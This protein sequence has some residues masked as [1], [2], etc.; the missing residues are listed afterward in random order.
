MFDRVYSFIQENIANI[1]IPTIKVTDVV[2]IAIISFVVYH[3]M[4]WIRKTKAWSLLKGLI[5]ILGFL[6]LAAIF[7][8]STIPANRGGRSF[9]KLYHQLPV[10][11]QPG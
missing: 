4:V 7:N 5:V 8:M 6:L 9:F 1:H 11:G 3:I 10:V 2:E